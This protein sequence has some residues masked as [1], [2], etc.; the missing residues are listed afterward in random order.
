M[1]KY[2]EAE[3]AAWLETKPES[4]QRIAA[5]YPPDCYTVEGKGHYLVAT[6]NENGTVSATHGRD[7]FL[8][9]CTVFGIPPASLE[10]C[11]CDQF[12]WATEDQMDAV[13]GLL[14]SMVDEGVS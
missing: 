1:V 2:T 12:Q 6:Y 4:I 9:G 7:S 10:R 14:D 8:P 11:G 13:Q 5:E 3:L